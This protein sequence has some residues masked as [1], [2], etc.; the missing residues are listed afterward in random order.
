[1]TSQVVVNIDTT[2]KNK[3][4]KMAKSQWL[5]MKALLSFCLQWY[6]DNEIEIGARISQHTRNNWELQLEKLSPEENAVINS[7]AILKH[8]PSKS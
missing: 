8:A 7:S 1:M 2:L 4:M 5:T 3:A 6:V